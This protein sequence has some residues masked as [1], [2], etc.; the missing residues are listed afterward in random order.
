MEAPSEFC[1]KNDSHLIF[2]DDS[3]VPITI[4]EIIHEEGYGQVS[5]L[6]AE[7]LPDAHD[8]QNSHGEKVLDLMLTRH[9]GSSPS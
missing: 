2:E 8:F 9:Y 6:K 7:I 5:V 1:F 3:R 4:Q